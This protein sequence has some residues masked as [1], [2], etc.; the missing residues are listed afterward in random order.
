M[1]WL[2]DHLQSLMPGVLRVKDGHGFALGHVATL[3]TC[4][5]RRRGEERRVQG[6]AGVADRLVVCQKG[7]VDGYAWLDVTA[8]QHTLELNANGSAIGA[9]IADYFGSTGTP[10]ISLP[11]SSR[12]E[13]EAVLYFLKTTNGTVTWTITNS[14]ANYANI[15][16]H[17]IQVGANTGIGAAGTGLA[18]GIVT[19]TTAA[20]AMAASGSLSTG[21]NHVFHV[22]ATIDMNAAGNVRLRAT[23]SAGTITPLR[24][25]YMKVRPLSSPV[26]DWVA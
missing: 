20:A 7:H 22:R 14:A 18:A 3:P 16:A 15:A 11:A 4:E 13:L 9:A 19:T 6:G 24:G 23:E 8:H 25:S 2:L 1:K 21:A 26:G 17:W 12:W 5:S 10:A